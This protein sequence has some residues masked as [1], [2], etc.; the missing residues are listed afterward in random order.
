MASY[1]DVMLVHRWDAPHDDT[2]WQAWLAEGRDF[3]QLIV[4]GPEDGFPAAVPLHFH[5]DGTST[6][7]AHLAAANPVWS[8]IEQRPNV[9]LSVLDDYA[10]IP[11]TWRAPARTPAEHGVPTSFYAA[12]QL[13]GRAEIVDD[14]SAKARLLGD[15]LDH[16]R[17]Q[18]SQVDVT[19]GERPYG[20]LLPAIRGIRLRVFQV[21]AK[22][23]YDDHKSAEHRARVADGLRERGEPRD[24][25]AEAQLTRRGLRHEPSE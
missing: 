8:A 17:H 24:A 6:V 7:T 15:Q 20:P 3:G 16:H 4:S 25:G 22:F 19:P 11:G 2:E 21:L 18:G 13:F 5:F 14:P 23:K 1:A 10:Y 9:L 12:V